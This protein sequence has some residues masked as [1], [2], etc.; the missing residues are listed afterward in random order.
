MDTPSEHWWGERDPEHC[1]TETP[2]REKYLNVILRP[3]PNVSGK[4]DLSKCDHCEMVC[5][6][7]AASILLTTHTYIFFMYSL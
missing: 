1:E 6:C 7:N 2:K 5:T 3:V 4:A